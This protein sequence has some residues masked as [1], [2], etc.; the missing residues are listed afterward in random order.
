MINNFRNI[1]STT[2]QST[3]SAT[4]DS[5]SCPVENNFWGEGATHVCPFAQNG[6]NVEYLT[7]NVEKLLLSSAEL[8]TAT[9]RLE[10]S[11]RQIPILAT[12]IANVE[13]KTVDLRK[14]TDSLFIKVDETTAYEETI[15]L[16][17]QLISQ[18]Q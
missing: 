9:D 7:Q 2:N 5:Q 18:S 13:E 3:T 6:N 11:S 8:R 15:I 4:S 10:I 17:Q 1:M 12:R 14:A 16:Q